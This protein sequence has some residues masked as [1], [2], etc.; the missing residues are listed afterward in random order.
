MLGS[1]SEAK[2]DRPE[3]ISSLEREPWFE[4]TLGSQTFWFELSLPVIQRQIAPCLHKPPDL[5]AVGDGL[6]VSAAQAL[7]EHAAP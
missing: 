5:A 4:F 1:R 3:L 6:P 2:V 7:A